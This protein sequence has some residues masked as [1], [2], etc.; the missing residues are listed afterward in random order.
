VNEKKLII[1]HIWTMDSDKAWK[2]SS[3]SCQ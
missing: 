1:G 2:F 3:N